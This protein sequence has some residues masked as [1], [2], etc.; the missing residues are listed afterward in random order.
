MAMWIRRKAMQS[1]RLPKAIA[2]LSHCAQTVLFYSFYFSLRRYQMHAQIMQNDCTETASC[3]HIGAAFLWLICLLIHFET[4]KHH[5]NVMP[6]GRLAVVG[7]AH[8]HREGTPAAFGPNRH[9]IR[10][11]RDL[12][13]DCHH[14]PM[15][16]SGR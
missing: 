5:D 4:C 13:R 11:M 3:L 7:R 16:G 9:G 8:P 15:D 6:A 2:M 10:H 14:M 12:L 1:N